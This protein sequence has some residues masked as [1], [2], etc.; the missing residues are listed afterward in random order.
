M[1]KQNTVVGLKSGTVRLAPYSRAWV[2]LF[3]KEAALLTEALGD[4]V[5]VD[6]QHVGSTSVPGLEAKPII[7]IALTIH[8]F[9][10]VSTCIRRLATIGYK[11][12]GEYG[13]PGRH[14]FTKGT[15][16]TH[17]LHVVKDTSEH[18]RHWLAFRDYLRKHKDTAVAYDKLKRS[19]ARKYRKN[20]DA[21]TSAKS[22]FVE[23][24]LS[25]AESH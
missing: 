1:A 9:R 16:T 24:I 3:K 14:F 6:I 7:D 17:H 11:Y 4:C 20:R 23:K 2:R 13:L 25:V 19:L 15:P 21:Y 10:R 12:M 18:W 22:A 5:P 8:D